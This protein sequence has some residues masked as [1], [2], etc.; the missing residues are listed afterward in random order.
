MLNTSQQF[1]D[2]GSPEGLRKEENNLSRLS[3]AV[4]TESIG[5]ATVA[6]YKFKYQMFRFVALIMSHTVKSHFRFT[7][8]CNFCNFSVCIKL[9]YSQPALYMWI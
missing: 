5:A 1:F 2:S 6:L 4:S 8:H 7:P 3:P 9:V